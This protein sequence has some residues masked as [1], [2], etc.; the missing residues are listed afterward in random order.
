ME[1]TWIFLLIFA[2]FDGTPLFA[3]LIDAAICDGLI[4]GIGPLINV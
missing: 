4:I 2:L 1:S 3:Q